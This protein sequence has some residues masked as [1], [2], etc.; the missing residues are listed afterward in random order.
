MTWLLVAAGA[1]VVLGA[2]VAI[3]ARDARSAA[4][5][6]LVVL[7]FSP[8]VADPLP[9]SP[10]LAFRIVAGVLTAYLLLVAARGAPGEAPSPLGLPAA[11]AAAAAAFVAGLGATAVGLPA[12]GPGAALAAGLACLAVAIPPVVRAGTPFRQGTSLVMILEGGLLVRAG[13]V[14]T[15]T[16]LEAVIAGI[17]LASLA[18]AVLA[19]GRSTAVA[20]AAGDAVVRD[21]AR[22]RLPVATDAARARR[23]GA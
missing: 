6:A 15:P 3:G 16:P 10:D 14:G 23:P 21:G 19:L 20:A 18:G 2:G 22:P 4:A 5:G 1:V 13:L 7:V 17:A 9:A 12:F 11:L 8:F